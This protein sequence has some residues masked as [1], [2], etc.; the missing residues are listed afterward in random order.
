MKTE[1]STSILTFERV[2]PVKGFSKAGWTQSGDVTNT[3]ELPNYDTRVF[4][5]ELEMVEKPRWALNRRFEGVE[6]QAQEKARRR[7]GRRGQAARADWTG[8]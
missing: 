3:I 1:R 2:A 7:I 4:L 8:A 5:G 6:A